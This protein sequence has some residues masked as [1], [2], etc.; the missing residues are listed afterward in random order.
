V[1]GHACIEHTRRSRRF[2][3]PGLRPTCLYWP[4]YHLGC[5]L[6]DQAPGPPRPPPRPHRRLRLPPGGHP[7]A[8][9]RPAPW[10]R[11]PGQCRRSARRPPVRDRGP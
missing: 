2:C 1:P 11:S 3:R 6:P 10:E 9:G 4:G 8:T 7:H 5:P